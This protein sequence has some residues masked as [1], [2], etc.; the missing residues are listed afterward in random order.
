M[1]HLAQDFTK[2]FTITLVITCLIALA[3][4]G[5]EFTDYAMDINAGNFTD[6]HGDEREGGRAPEGLGMLIYVL[7]LVKIS[8]MTL[9][10]AAIWVWTAKLIDRFRKQ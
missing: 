4:W 10:P 7:P 5:F 6:E 8:V 9:V 2:R 3:M 1:N